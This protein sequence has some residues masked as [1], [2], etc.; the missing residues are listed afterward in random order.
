[1][2]ITVPL[3]VLFGLMRQNLLALCLCTLSDPSRLLCFSYSI[4]VAYFKFYLKV[5]CVDEDMSCSDAMWMGDFLRTTRQK[6][7]TLAAVDRTE[8]ESAN[9]H[10]GHMC[11]SGRGKCSGDQIAL[12]KSSTTSVEVVVPEKLLLTITHYF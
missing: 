11:G 9:K 10:I 6:L 8:E 3:C 4:S 2:L 1:M 12:D 5:C 7:I